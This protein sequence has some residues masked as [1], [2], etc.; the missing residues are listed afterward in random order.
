[1][2]LDLEF[3]VIKGKPNQEL[4]MKLMYQRALERFCTYA[5]HNMKDFLNDT[6]MK[7]K[8][9]FLQVQY[10]SRSESKKDA[11]SLWCRFQSFSIVTDTLS[12]LTPK[13]M[14]TYFPITKYYQGAKYNEKDH[15]SSLKMVDQLGLDCVIG[16]KID[17]FLWD[18]Q[19]KDLIKFNMKRIMNL[20]DLRKLEAHKGLAEEFAKKRGVYN[21]YA[22]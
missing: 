9:L 6:E 10:L 21:L 2:T 20:S 15:Y 11:E 12:T 22:L 3:K 17:D 1:M 8:Y 19:N 16:E 4:S 7:M 13:L 5:L 14:L 18:Y